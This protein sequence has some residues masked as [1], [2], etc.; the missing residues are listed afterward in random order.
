MK[1][2]QQYGKREVSTND[3]LRVFS[4]YWKKDGEDPAVVITLYH[5]K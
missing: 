1:C 5:I 4:L 2:M 3:C